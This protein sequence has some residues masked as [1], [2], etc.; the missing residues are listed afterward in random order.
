MATTVRFLEIVDELA[1][2]TAGE[3]PQPALYPAAVRLHREAD[4]GEW[5]PKIAG[6]LL[7]ALGFQLKYEP[8]EG[9]DDEHRSGRTGHGNRRLDPGD[10]SRA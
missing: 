4:R 5:D 3:L 9:S 8:A 10:P 1:M 7:S 6:E 2:N